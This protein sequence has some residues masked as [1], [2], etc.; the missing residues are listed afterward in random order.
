MRRFLFTPLIVLILM[1]ASCENEKKQTSNIMKKEDKLT[2]LKETVQTLPKQFKFSY[3]GQNFQVI[4]LFDEMLDYTDNILNDEGVDKEKVYRETIVEPFMEITNSDP[5]GNSYFSAPKVMIEKLENNTT[6]MMENLDDI[7]KVVEKVLINSAKKL[8]GH[9]IR[10]FIMPMRPDNYF[11]IINMKGVTG[12]ASFSGDVIVIEIDPSFNNEVFEYAVA[13]EYH[14]TVALREQIVFAEFTESVLDM[15]LLEGKAE[16]FAKMLYPEME[17]PW[18][19]PLSDEAMEVVLK[20]VKENPFDF[21]LYSEL[22]YG[23]DEYPKWANYRLGYAI[24]ESYL[25]EN[26]DMLPVEWTK[27][28]SE[29]IINGSEYSQLLNTD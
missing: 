16:T 21:A 4:S 9:D 19:E 17:V 7:K 22:Q 14:H 23:T 27:L 8:P 15:V 12:V 2:E 11:G 18:I 13:H 1:L 25:I 29:E 10:V 3:E 24:M 28:S 5:L 26:Q 20:K 6:E